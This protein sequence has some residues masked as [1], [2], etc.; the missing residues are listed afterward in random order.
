MKRLCL[1]KLFLSLTFGLFFFYSPIIAQNEK[2]ASDMSEL[3]KQS[4]NPVAA[5]YQLPVSYLGD[6]NSGLTKSYIS[7]VMLKPVIPITL[8][9]SL[10][11]IF[12]AIVPVTFMPSP[13]N[14]RGL[15][16]IQLQ[17]YLSPASKSKFIWGAGPMIS[18]PSGIPS[19]MCS[20]KWTVGPAAVGLLMLKHW[21]IGVLATQRWT[22]AGNGSMPDINQLYIDA[23]ANYNF[24]HGWAL[25][26]TPEIYV[27]WNEPDDAWNLPVGLNVSKVFKIGK[28]P[29]SANL[30]GYYNVIRP[31]DYADMYIKAG[32]TFLFPKK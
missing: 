30:A 3:A 24:K 21:V 13:I 10:L 31:A 17:F 5:M 27:N 12:R 6:I 19:D 14:K 15:S 22:F 23:F 2:A 8:S 28:Q 16:D 4:Q 20:G 7:T 25:G 32:L 26:Y 1:T 11:F 9:K 29:L 18:V